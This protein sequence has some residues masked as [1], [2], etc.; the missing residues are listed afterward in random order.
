VHVKRGRQSVE[1][2]GGA[3]SPNAL[4]LMFVPKKL[5]VRAAEE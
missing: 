2:G 3:S 4:R 5:F 1:G